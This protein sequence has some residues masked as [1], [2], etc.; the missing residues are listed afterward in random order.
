VE[1]SRVEIEDSEGK[2]LFRS[3]FFTEL[4]DVWKIRFHLFGKIALVFEEGVEHFFRTP[5]A[6]AGTS[7]VGW[8]SDDLFEA[9]KR[10]YAACG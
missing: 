10:V 1:I 3:D 9:R 2:D 5:G 8:G 7:G 6:C 4:L